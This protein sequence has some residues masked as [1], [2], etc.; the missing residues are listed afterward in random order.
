MSREKAVRGD[1]MGKLE[2]LKA[3]EMIDARHPSEF[4]VSQSEQWDQPNSSWTVRYAYDTG[5]VSGRLISDRQLRLVLLKALAY[6]DLM[7]G[8]LHPEEK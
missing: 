2:L 6:D 4:C 5:N 8:I 7:S 3:I 1:P